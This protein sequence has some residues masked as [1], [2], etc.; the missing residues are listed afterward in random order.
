M[1]VLAPVPLAF[2]VTASLRRLIYLKEI[3]SE[4]VGAAFTA[5]QRLDVR[6]SHRRAIFSLA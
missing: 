2:E 4:D 3:S 6:Y 5:F 1:D